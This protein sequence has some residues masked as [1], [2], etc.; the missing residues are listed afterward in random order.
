MLGD[1]NAI[2]RYDV[3]VR[4]HDFFTLGNAYIMIEGKGFFANYRVIYHSTDV[5][6]KIACTTEKN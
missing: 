4:F 2:V 1:V 5:R 6:A 3:R